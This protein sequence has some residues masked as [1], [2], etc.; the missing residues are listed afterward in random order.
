MLLGESGVGVRGADRLGQDPEVLSR[1]I[2]SPLCLNCSSKEG[3]EVLL[4]HSRGVCWGPQAGSSLPFLNSSMG[5]A[6]AL[7][8]GEPDSATP[9]HKLLLL[10]T[11][12]PEATSWEK[13]WKFDHC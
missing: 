6:M 9:R 3:A 7:G 8:P 2:T 13:W 10:K 4:N 12:R 5:W 1:E 11:S